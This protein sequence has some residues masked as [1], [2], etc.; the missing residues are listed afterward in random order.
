LVVIALGIFV[1]VAV[2]S[3]ILLLTLPGE[4]AGDEARPVT[5]RPGAGQAEE[6]REKAPDEEAAAPSSSEDLSAA[7]PMEPREEIILV[8]GRDSDSDGLSDAEE[9][10]YG[11]DPRH[12]DTDRDSYLDGNE[13]YHLFHPALPSPMGLEDAGAL[14][15]LSVK[16]AGYE[17]LYP[18]SWRAQV[19]GKET[20]GLEA[21][22]A[23]LYAPSGEVV[24]VSAEQKPEEESLEAWYLRQSP[25]VEASELQAFYTK[26][27]V[28][29]LTNPDRLTT[30]L[31]QGETVSIIHYG[32]G[33]FEEMD[34]LTTYQMV[35]NSFTRVE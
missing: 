27:G 9:E 22:G 25:G 29:A 18:R 21:G 32:L 6:D 2:A 12:P 35:V 14:L 30:Y 4:E 28:R 20:G 34:F 19:A 26:T 15:R 31:D 24:T 23:L 33:P 16:E 17:L 13:V 10:L 11:S 1:S 8:L 3:G 5:D 7:P